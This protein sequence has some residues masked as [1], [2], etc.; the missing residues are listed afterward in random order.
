MACAHLSAAAS[1]APQSDGCEECLARGE[2]WVHLRVCLTCG[3]VGCCDSSQS[4]HAAEHF[5]RTGHPIIQAFQPG[6]G[7]GWCFIDECL[8]P[9]E[10]LSGL[11]GA[12]SK[13]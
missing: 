9:P 4:R 11:R 8:L 2:R 1:A 10:A 7:W 12:S 3:H 13:F 5:Q 6:E